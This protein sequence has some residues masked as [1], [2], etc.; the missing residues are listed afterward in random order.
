M[1]SSLEPI[2]E[3]QLLWAVD[4]A[5]R[6]GRQSTDHRLRVTAAEGLRVC[7]FAFTLI[8]FSDHLRGKLSEMAPP[9]LFPQEAVGGVEKPTMVGVTQIAAGWTS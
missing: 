5:G 1:V 8:R 6:R 4:G 7:P 3:F 2:P 9:P